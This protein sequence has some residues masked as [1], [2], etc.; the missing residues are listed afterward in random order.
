MSD[1]SEINR[2]KESGSF[3]FG[4]RLGGSLAVSRAFGDVEFKNAGLIAKPYL[5][6]TKLLPG[7]THLILACDGVTV[8][9]V[10]ANDPLQ[11]WDVISDQSAVDLV[12][13]ESEPQKMSDDLLQYAL[14]N[15]SK[16]NVSV[17][18]LV[19]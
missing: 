9:I 4:G 7:D 5:S 16:D 1:E 6:E 14:E 19:L 11:L 17:M 8:L 12:R 2:V 13:T 15:G 18:V 10:L 3:I